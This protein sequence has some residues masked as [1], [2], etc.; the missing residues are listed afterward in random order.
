MKANV[1]AV[2]FILVIL[3]VGVILVIPYLDTG[4][5]KF[6]VTPDPAG[7]LKLAAAKGRPVFLEFYSAG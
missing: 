3:A 2:I 7:K 1:K 5:G 4:P 6:A